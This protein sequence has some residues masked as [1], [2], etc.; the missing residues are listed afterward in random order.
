MPINFLIIQSIRKYGKFYG[1]S[2]QVECPTG[3]GNKMNLEKVADELTRRVI[4]LFIRDQEGKRKLHDTYNWFYQK[5]ENK[6]L[7]LFF[8]YFHGDTGRGLGASHQTGWTALVA[9]LISE[10]GG[11]L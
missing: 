1:D 6:D 9:E 5:P 11:K 2:L 10:Y 7:L 8:E 4:S 3:S